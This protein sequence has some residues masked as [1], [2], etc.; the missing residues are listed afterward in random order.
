MLKALKSQR[1]LVLNVL[2]LNTCSCH[3]QAHWVESAFKS[4][5]L[6]CSQGD[7]GPPGPPGNSTHPHT[8]PPYGPAV[9]PVQ[10]LHI[11]CSACEYLRPEQDLKKFPFTILGASWWKGSKR[12]NWRTGSYFHWNNL[13]MFLIEVQ[14]QVLAD[15]LMLFFSHLGWQQGG[16]W[17][18]RIWWSPGK[19]KLSGS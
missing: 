12:R 18:D 9:C 11:V 10:P 8:L 5:P 6:L 13:T 16:V 14:F 1:I 4:P 17:C 3:A 19:T 15:F 2:I 7:I